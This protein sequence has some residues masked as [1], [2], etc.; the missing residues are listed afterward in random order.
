MPDKE[1]RDSILCEI[2]RVVIALIISLSSDK[3]KIIDVIKDFIL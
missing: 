2:V 3:S 1:C